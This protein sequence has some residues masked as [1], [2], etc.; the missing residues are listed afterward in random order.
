MPTLGT[1]SKIQPHTL[2]VRLATEHDL[3]LFH[4]ILYGKLEYRSYEFPREPRPPFRTSFGA[5]AEVHQR[6]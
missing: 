3:P 1:I 4:R 6:K 5:G 2:G